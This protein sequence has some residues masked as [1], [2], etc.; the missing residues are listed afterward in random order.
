MKRMEM[1]G[2]F[3]SQRSVKQ[4]EGQNPIGRKKG[5]KEEE[6]ETEMLGMVKERKEEGRKKWGDAHLKTIITHKSKFSLLQQHTR[7]HRLGCCKPL[8]PWM[9]LINTHIKD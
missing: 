2:D 6:R 9:L 4:T 1:R 5:K 3:L 7:T 8:S